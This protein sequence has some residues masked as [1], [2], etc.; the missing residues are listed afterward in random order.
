M[1]AVLRVSDGSRLLLIKNRQRPESFG[2]LGGVIKF[3][4]SA[5]LEDRFE[6]QSQSKRSDLGDDLR[7]FLPARN[8]YAFMKW[9]RSKQD[10]EV[11]SVTRE[12]VEELREIYL[13]ELANTIQSLPLSFV[14]HVHEGVQHV[15]GTHYYQF[16]YLEVY[17]LNPTDENGRRLTQ[18]LFSAVETNDHLLAV[19]HREIMRRRSRSGHLI[20]VHSGYLVGRKRAGP[21]PA[22]FYE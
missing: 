9:F 12:L 19:T 20:G 1:A 11:E 2:P 4:A 15:P 3:Y 13:D 7:G 14:R 6:F 5:K 8:F 16:R 17:E 21:E 22:P 18:E 10:R